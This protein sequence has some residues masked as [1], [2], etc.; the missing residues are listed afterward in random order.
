[1]ASKVQKD[2]DVGEGPVIVRGSTCRPRPV[3]LCQLVL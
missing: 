3:W 2:G 1:M